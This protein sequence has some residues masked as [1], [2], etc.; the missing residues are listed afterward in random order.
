MNTETND[1]KFLTNLLLDIFKKFKTSNTFYI[2]EIED[3]KVLRKIRSIDKENQITL[4]LDKLS[5]SEI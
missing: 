5:K 2:S 3:K 1:L 4:I